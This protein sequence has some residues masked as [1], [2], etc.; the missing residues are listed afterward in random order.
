MSTKTCAFRIGGMMCASCEAAVKRALLELPGVIEAD[1]SLAEE[2]AKASYDPEVTSEEHMI[3]AVRKAGYGAVPAARSKAARYAR[4]VATAFVIFILYGLLQYFGLLNLLVPAQLAETGMSYGMLFLVGV[5]TSVHC[6]AMC[7]GI[8]LSQCVGT[9]A[10]VNPGRTLAPAFLYNAGRVASYTAI[11]FALGGVG[12]LL[13]AGGSSD[14]LPTA[15]Q[16]ALKIF[17]GLLMVAMGCNMLSLFPPLKKLRPRQPKAILAGLNGKRA[18]GRHPFI[19]GLINGLMPCGPL[20][21]MQIIALG[22]GSPI[23]GAFSMFAFSLGTAPLM[24]GLGGVVSV[25]G[26]KHAETVTRTSSVLV[27]VLGLAML[28]QGAALAGILPSAKTSVSNAVPGTAIVSAEGDVQYVESALDFGS[29][30]NITV[31][32]NV[33]VKWTV[34]VPEEVINGCNYKMLIPA[35]DIEHEFTPGD[36]VIEF[37]PTTTESV[38]YTCWMGMINGTINVIDA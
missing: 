9:N 38:N 11:G 37:T 36:N 34:H 10:S 2:K 7:G 21:S 6:V 17:A 3:E 24:L 22:T 20:Q 26:K 30:P 25:L 33:P 31:Y 19:V 12:A 27:V 8:G 15:L 5:L 13:T 16:G 14:G 4:T 28:T 1:V 32:A 18:K 35:Y 29:Y 23:A